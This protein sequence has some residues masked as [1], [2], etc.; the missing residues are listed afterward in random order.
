MNIFIICSKAFYSLIPEIKVTLEVN[1]HKALLPNC[2]D[3][4][5]TEMEV[6][7]LGEKEHAEFKASM[8]RK[9]EKIISSVDAVLVLNFNKNGIPGYIGG[10]TFL[11]MYDAFRLGKSIYLFNDI[12]DNLLSDEIKGFLPI[13]ING[14]LSKIILAK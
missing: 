8:F 12:S 11:E 3:Q 9:S 1:G 2:Y 14:D 7:K 4:P 13:I 6:K 5:E 10:A